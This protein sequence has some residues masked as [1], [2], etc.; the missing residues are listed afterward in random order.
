[1]R[2]AEQFPHGRGQWLSWTA[3]LVAGIILIRLIYSL[4]GSVA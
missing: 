1:M 3:I 2:D 4:Y